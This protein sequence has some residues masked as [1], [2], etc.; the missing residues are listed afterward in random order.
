LKYTDFVDL[1]YEPQETDL[2]CTFT[3]EP[4]GMDLRE[5]SGGIAAESSVGTWTELTTQKPYVE[6]LAAHVYS[7]EGNT[8]KIAYPIELFEADNMPNILSSVAGNVFGLRALKNLRLQ[9]IKFPKDITKSFKGPQYGIDGIRQILKVKER[10]L[11]GTIIKPKLG[12]K[13]EDHAQ[14]AYAAWVGGCDIV[15]D[16]ENLSSQKFNPFEKRLEQTL[17]VRDRAEKETGE[18]KIY[19]INITAET[20]IMLERA[21]KVIDQG[22][23]YVMVDILTCGWS[24]LQTLRNQNRRL[25]I[26]AHRAGHAAFTK[27]PLHGIA[28]RTIAK[29]ARVVGV[30]Q[31]HVGTV[32]GKMSETKAEVLENIDALKNEMHGLKPVMPVASGGLHPRLIPALLETF[33]NDVVIQAGGGIHGH[34]EGTKVGALAMRHSI[35]A[36]MQKIPLEEYARNHIELRGAL[37]TWKE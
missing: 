18:K 27:N 29:I 15:K 6:N 21:D 26:H 10:P 4:E 14:V 28:M 25:V 32:V 8:V 3:L 1:T 5:A 7:M 23:E 36:A 24:A 9:D 12:L 20:Q 22:G 17:E 11:I 30:D 37:E 34:P 19:M 33:G 13:T 16:D 35:D 31:L 2:I